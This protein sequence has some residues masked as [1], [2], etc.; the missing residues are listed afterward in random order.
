M[1]VFVIFTKNNNLVRCLVIVHLIIIIIIIF[2]KIS[3]VNLVHNCR[4]RY[5]ILDSILKQNHPCKKL[6]KHN[7]THYTIS[8][9]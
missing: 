1:W 6:V 5:K 8:I 7:F 9:L 4:K 2:F 3:H